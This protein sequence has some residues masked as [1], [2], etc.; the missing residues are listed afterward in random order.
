MEEK[1]VRLDDDLAIGEKLI[2]LNNVYQQMRDYTSILYTKP[3]QIDSRELLEYCTLAGHLLSAEEIV[4]YH[5]YAGLLAILS[6]ANT[7]WPAQVISQLEIAELKS[8]ITPRPWANIVT[9]IEL[10]AILWLAKEKP[11]K[12]YLV[13]ALYRCGDYVTNQALITDHPDFWQLL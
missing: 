3:E 4:V 12:Q 6:R 9:V 13:D 7:A 2:C 10:P 11:D 5:L 8:L 1:T